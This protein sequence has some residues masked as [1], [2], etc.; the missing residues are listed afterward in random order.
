MAKEKTCLFHFEL[1]LVILLI[2]H[3]GAVEAY[4]LI[5]SG[6]HWNMLSCQQAQIQASQ[7]F[8]DDN[9]IELKPNTK[10]SECASGIY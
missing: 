7:L 4:I 5:L 2:S 3:Q 1:Y 10:T 9:A 6:A 8:Q